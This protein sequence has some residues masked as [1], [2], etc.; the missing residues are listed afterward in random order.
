MVIGY[1]LTIMLG[2]QEVQKSK[3]KL[4]VFRKGGIKMRLLSKVTILF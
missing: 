3:R 4:P 1:F 2:F